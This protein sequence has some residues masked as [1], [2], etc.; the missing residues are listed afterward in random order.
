MDKYKPQPVI[1]C[2]VWVRFEGTSWQV[3]TVTRGDARVVCR[4]YRI[5]LDSLFNDAKIIFVSRK[6]REKGS[7]PVTRALGSSSVRIAGKVN[8]TLNK[9]NLVL[10]HPFPSKAHRLV[11]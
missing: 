4:P 2:K 7:F 10:A 11:G 3:G 1:V 9:L 6:A 8:L 5:F